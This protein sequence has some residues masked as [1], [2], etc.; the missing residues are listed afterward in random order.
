MFSC[1]FIARTVV[2]QM[3][4]AVASVSRVCWTVLCVIVW[5]IHDSNDIDRIFVFIIFTC[6]II[7]LANLHLMNPRF[8]LL[9]EEL[10]ALWPRC[11][12]KYS[13]LSASKSTVMPLAR[14]FLACL[15]IALATFFRLRALEGVKNY[16]D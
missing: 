1:F 5:V 14:S 4:G 10:V 12:D 6:L 7:S 3:I 11:C 8:D 13:D 16:K 2:D 9:S 15:S